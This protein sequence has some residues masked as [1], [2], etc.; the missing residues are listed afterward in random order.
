MKKLSSGTSKY[1]ISV[2]N[3]STDGSYSVT[4]THALKDATTYKDSQYGLVKVGSE[5]SGGNTIGVN[6][7][8]D[9][10]YYIQEG[11]HSF[12]QTSSGIKTS[13]TAT[14]YSVS[15]SFSITEGYQGSSSDS[16]KTY[17]QVGSHSLSQTASGIKTSSTATS[18][19]VSASSSVGEGYQ[20]SSSEPK[21]ATTYIQEGSISQS[22]VSGTGT[23][24][25]VISKNASATNVNSSNAVTTKPSGYYVGVNTASQTT[26][27]VSGTVSITEGY[28]KAATKTVSGNVALNGS[29]VYYIPITTAVASGLTLGNTAWSYGSRYIDFGRNGIPLSLSA[30]R[31]A[32]VSIT[33]AGYIPTGVVKSGTVSA[34]TS[35]E[36]S[37]IRIPAERELDI[38]SNSGTLIYLS[39]WRLSQSGTTLV[40]T[41]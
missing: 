8:A 39:R 23:F 27:T 5:V 21:T 15:A 16:A 31:T 4:T 29:G 11:S 33:T 7:S 32:S 24:T 37:A 17:I 19:S 25:P 41:L 28:Q 38:E 30:S 14:N 22:E 2:A 13:S 26:K 20:K 1:I 36:I 3:T 18:Y 34:S 10:T 6:K 40:F 35:D 9:A 12:S